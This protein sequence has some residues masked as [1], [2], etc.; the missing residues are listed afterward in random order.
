MLKP[1]ESQANW[2]E[3]YSDQSL[4]YESQFHSLVHRNWFGDGDMPQTSPK[5]LSPET[6][7]ETIEK[8]SVFQPPL[9]N[10]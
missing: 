6:F 9:L 2:D 3:F 5:R 4:A 7:A 10:R 8:V 1:E